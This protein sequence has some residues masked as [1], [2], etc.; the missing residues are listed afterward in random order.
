VLVAE[1]PVLVA[2]AVAVGV[3]WYFGRYFTVV[4]QFDLLPSG[5]AGMKSPVWTEPRT[6]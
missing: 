5:A 2:V 6:L 4:G 1:A 3:D